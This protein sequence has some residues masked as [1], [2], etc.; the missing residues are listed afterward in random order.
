M[1]FESAFAFIRGKFASRSA[2]ALANSPLD[3]CVLSGSANICE[4]SAFR[5]RLQRLP[6]FW[7]ACGAAERL[8]FCPHRSIFADTLHAP[9][10]V[11][12]LDGE[13]VEY[14]DEDPVLG[15]FAVL[16]AIQI[17]YAHLRWPR[18]FG[19]AKVAT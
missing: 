18:P 11:E 12:P 7:K 1:A 6:F 13:I 9:Q 16:Y 8:S 5:L 14:V 2:A 4:S 10:H 15:E 17:D 19:H 3:R